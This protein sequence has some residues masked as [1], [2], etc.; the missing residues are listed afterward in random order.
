M[1]IESPADW[2]MGRRGAPRA[3]I[4]RTALGSGCISRTGVWTAGHVHGLV[5][6]RPPAYFFRCLPVT[7]GA[8]EDS[9]ICLTS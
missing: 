7:F 9:N 6:G 1:A 3:R 2:Y 4:S 8:A 5:T